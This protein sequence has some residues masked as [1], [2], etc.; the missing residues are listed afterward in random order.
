[1]ARYSTDFYII[2]KILYERRNRDFQ[3]RDL[4]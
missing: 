4:S 3:A 2:G 1:M